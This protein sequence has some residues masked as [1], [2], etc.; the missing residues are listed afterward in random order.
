M[1]LLGT[2][3]DC[4][5]L[6]CAPADAPKVVAVAR[7]VMS[8]ADVGAARVD[9]ADKL[10]KLLSPDD[11]TKPAR[12]NVVLYLVAASAGKLVAVSGSR[13]LKRG[14]ASSTGGRDVVVPSRAGSQ[15]LRSI[16]AIAFG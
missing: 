10:F 3:G 15:A 11:A 6:Q 8:G 12:T 4:D 1:E 13:G 2:L 14:T 7:R 5:G 9:L 16:M